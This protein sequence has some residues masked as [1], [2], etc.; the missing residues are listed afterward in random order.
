[1]AGIIVDELNRLGNL[2]VVEAEMTPRKAV[3]IGGFG[4]S[5]E[6]SG[7]MVDRVSALALYG[8]PL[9]EVN[10]YI[11]GV[12]KVTAANVRQFAS[13]N[14]LGSSASIVIV[15]DAKLFIEPLR[16]RFPGAEVVPVAEL[17]LNAATLRTAAK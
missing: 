9:E 8:L 11:P 15:G 10:R 14:L 3:L 6:T 1:V 12:Q 7:G 17:N 13:S 4:R 16:K 5:L 2:D